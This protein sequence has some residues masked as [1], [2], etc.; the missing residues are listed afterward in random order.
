MGRFLL[1]LLL[2][3]GLAAG[4]AYYYELPPFDSRTG[5]VVPPDQPHDQPRVQLGKI[6]YVLQAPSLNPIVDRADPDVQKLLG[7]P[8]VI[9]DS[10][11]VTINK[12]EASSGKD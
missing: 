2:A 9:P 5:G 11:L 12:Q 10:H 4:I 8:I 6:L 7:Q 3:T 1:T